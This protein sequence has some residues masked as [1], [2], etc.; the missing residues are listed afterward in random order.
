MTCC[1]I[2]EASH[3]I[4]K[5]KKNFIAIL[6]KLFAF[7]AAFLCECQDNAWSIFI[8]FSIEDAKVKMARS[9]LVEL[10]L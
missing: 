2:G 4:D 3:E 7:F 1:S 8:I 5:V 10:S 6:E 9:D